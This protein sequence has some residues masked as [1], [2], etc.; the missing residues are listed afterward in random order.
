MSLCLPHLLSPA[1]ARQGS[2]NSGQA[3]CGRGSP[4]SGVCDVC[5]RWARRCIAAKVSPPP[6][7]LDPRHTAPARAR[8]QLG[9]PAQLEPLDQVRRT[10]FVR[11]RGRG[12]GRHGT[13]PCAVWKGGL[14]VVGIG[15]KLVVLTGNL[16]CLQTSPLSLATTALVQGSQAHTG[17]T[18]R[19]KRLSREPAP[20]ERG[21]VS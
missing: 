9:V 18:A 13:K 1:I 7:A 2:K 12:G 21:L 15:R 14:A 8:A 6:V 10:A 3:C 4:R 16:D 17:V 20:F 19:K 11:G 5:T